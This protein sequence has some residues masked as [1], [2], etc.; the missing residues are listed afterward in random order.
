MSE[1][2]WSITG[3]SFRE[4]EDGNI[5]DRAKNL[6]ACG[7]GVKIDLDQIVYPVLDHIHE[8]FHNVFKEAVN[9]R[10]DSFVYPGVFKSLQRIVGKDLE[11]YQKKM[12]EA[13]AI[14]SPEAIIELF[15]SRYNLYR[16]FD[17]LHE[18][19]ERRQSE[20]YAALEKV[21]ETHKIQKENI[22]FAKG[23][24]IQGEVDFILND[25]VSYK[26]NETLFTLSNNDTIITGDSI[27]EPH[28]PISVFIAI[29]NAL[30]DLFIHGAYHNIR[31]FPVYDG[32]EE[33]VKKFKTALTFYQEYYRKNNVKIEIVDQGPLH[34]KAHLIGA[35]TMA[36]T[37]NRPPT[38]HELRPGQ[39]ILLTHK[40]GD[41]A[42]LSVYRALFKNNQDNED[43]KSW[44]EE[45]LRKL[46]RSHFDMSQVISKYLPLRHESYDSKKHICF[47]SDVSGP[48]LSVL[49][50]ASE[51]SG[52]SIAIDN[53]ELITDDILNYPRKNYTTST[54][55]PWLLVGEEQVLEKIRE[56]LRKLGLSEAH[57]IGETLKRENPSAVYVKKQLVA[58]Y[59]SPQYKFNLF[60]PEITV[61][62][63]AGE[64]QIQC[65]LFKRMIK[66]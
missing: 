61:K 20:K 45:V 11:E 12:L 57:Y 39:K 4:F 46:M 35:T 34:V 29:N 1:I 48:G 36:E 51:Q 62:T 16:E 8:K 33:Q 41:L 44:R 52:V 30:N 10:R 49:E 13:L 64:K 63:A 43:Y 18:D 21:F 7:C 60:Y 32:N 15:S 6:R 5:V 9:E 23:H 28:S 56:D 53:I 14:T 42:I 3:K 2:N 50:E 31:I 54:N 19:F 17:K 59:S 37:H 47:A 58:Q 24:S 25:L 66:L 40:L 38:F 55:G 65:P 27:L 22:Q 26:E